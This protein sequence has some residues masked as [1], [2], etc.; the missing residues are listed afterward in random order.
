MQQDMEDDDDLAGTLIFS[1]EATFHLSGKKAKLNHCAPCDFFLWDYAKDKVY[2][3]PM[4]TTLQTLQERST[5]AVK[6]IDGNMLLNV[7]RELDY[8][9]DVCRVTKGVHI[10]HL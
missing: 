8:H 6:D 3:P 10:E 9:W 4:P 5:A 7:W 1:D 2:V